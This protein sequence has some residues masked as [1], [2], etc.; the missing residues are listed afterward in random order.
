M[1]FC[2]SK[3]AKTPL[4]LVT[5]ERREGG[6]ENPLSFRYVPLCPH[7]V[8]EAQ[9][10]L[11]NQDQSLQQVESFLFF[12]FC[13]DPVAQGVHN[14]Q[15]IA[16]SS[17]SEKPLLCLLVAVFHLT[18]EQYKLGNSMECG[19]YEHLCFLKVTFISEIPL[20]ESIA[21]GSLT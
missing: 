9:F 12:S 20:G 3:Q 2:F 16:S 1:V 11:A 10:P 13:V 5:G 4:L 18:S 7:C 15:V 17:N 21:S 14:S 8:A 19:R 6:L